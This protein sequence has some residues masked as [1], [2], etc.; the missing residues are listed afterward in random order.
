MKRISK[1]DERFVDLARHFS[2][3]SKDP[4]TQTGA[5]IVSPTRT[6]ILPGYNGFAKG[7]PDDPAIY[8]DRETKYERIIHCEMNAVL[9]GQQSVR[10]FTLYTY[11]FLSCP[12]CAVHMIQCGIIRCV[13]PKVDAERM[14][15][16]GD[17]MERT[18]ERFV[19][20]GVD[21][22]EVDMLARTVHAQF[23]ARPRV[24]EEQRKMLGVPRH[25]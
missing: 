2:K 23:I 25:V 6:T 3:Y 7:V 12:R 22:T 9:L 16:W 21:W 1:W 13:A 5:V 10:G 19:E 8:A 4:S 15:R 14:D 24:T 20:A 18:K 11:P 17:A